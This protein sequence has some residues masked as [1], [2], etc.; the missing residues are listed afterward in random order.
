[1]SQ[2]K[3]NVESLRSYEKTA[4]KNAEAFVEVLQGIKACVDV[5]G[6]GTGSAEALQQQ[7]VS[8]EKAY[9]EEVVPSVTTALTTLAT[10]AE[11]A[12]EVQ[13]VMAS[14]SAV[15][16]SAISDVEVTQGVQPAAF[17]QGF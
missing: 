4:L 17:S 5:A 10:S 16:T 7:G 3:V 11:N 6:E 14:V 9:N 12:E 13:K 2:V 8:L 1:M 15:S